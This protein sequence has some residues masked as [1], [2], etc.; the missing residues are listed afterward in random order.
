MAAHIVRSGVRETH[1]MPD[2]TPDLTPDSL[3]DAEEPVPLR[4]STRPNVDEMSEASFPAS[5]PPA[6]WTWDPP[7]N[8]LG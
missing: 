7:P 8:P 2:Q 5:D 1:H 6:V 4:P 3:A